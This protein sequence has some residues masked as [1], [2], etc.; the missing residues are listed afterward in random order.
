MA[1]YKPTRPHKRRS[2]NYLH[3]PEVKGK[4]VDQVEVDPDAQAVTILFQDKTLLSFDVDSRHYIFPEL[5]DYKTGNWK[6]IKRWPPVS[7]SLS[8]VKWL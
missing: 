7:S 5:S 1:N 3:F 2:R 8:L 4:I 6:G